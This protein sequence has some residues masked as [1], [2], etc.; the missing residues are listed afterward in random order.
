MAPGNSVHSLGTQL[1]ADTLTVAVV[2]WIGSPVCEPHVCRCRANVNT[3]RLHNLVC[4]FGA[5]RLASHAKL[6]D[7]IKRALQ[8]SGV[9]CLPEPEMGTL[10]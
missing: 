3:L 8:T 4:R 7:V 10:R 5:D 6:D 2:L 1:D 9:P